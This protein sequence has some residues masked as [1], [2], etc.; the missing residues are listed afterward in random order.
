[1]VVESHH[2]ATPIDPDAIHTRA[3]FKEALGRLVRPI[4]VRHAAK[5]T[6]KLES[7]PGELFEPCSVSTIST[8]LNPTKAL[9]WEAHPNRPWAL[10]VVCGIQRHERE[11]SRWMSA[12][13]RTRADTAPNTPDFPATA[14]DEVLQ[15]TIV[16]TAIGERTGR[17]GTATQATRL[18]DIWSA[19]LLKGWNKDLATIRWMEPLLGVGW[20]IAALHPDEWRMTIEAGPVWR[21]RQLGWSNDPELLRGTDGELTD[22]FLTQVPRRTLVA[23]ESG[24]GK[25]VLLHLARRAQISDLPYPVLLSLRAWD[26][27]I[28]LQDWLERELV[29]GDPQLG[30]P[31]SDGPESLASEALRRGWLLPILDGRDE[32]GLPADRLRTV[33]SLNDWLRGDDRPGLVVASRPLPDGSP[34]RGPLCSMTARVE[35]LPAGHVM[36]YLVAHASGPIWRDLMAQAPDSITKALVRPLSVWLATIYRHLDTSPEELLSCKDPD[37]VQSRLVSHLIPV[38][39]RRPANR[40]A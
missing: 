31:A 11:R 36:P 35:P 20:Q 6:S 38:A 17:A 14:P 40:R 29:R 8:W 15:P 27:R 22:A 34:P 5:L 4:G 2:A 26:H 7:G 25:S 10:L 23:G 12:L 9:P 37:E 21:D 33:E 24:A 3:A 28:P 32:V 39:Y 19:Q 1:M 16:S 30:R 13:S 18:L